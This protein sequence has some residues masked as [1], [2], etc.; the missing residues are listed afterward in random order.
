MAAGITFRIGG[1]LDPSYRA[2]LAQS[3]TEAKAA[4]MQIEAQQA[5]I[6]RSL[7]MP[8]NQIYAGQG[9]KFIQASQDLER[10][11]TAILINENAIRDSI[12]KK[13]QAYKITQAAAF[14]A[15]GQT[16]FAQSMQQSVQRIAAIRAEEAAMAAATVAAR[17]QQIAA[18]E[19]IVAGAASGAGGGS[20]GRA[21]MT[22]VIRESLVIMR[23]IAMGRGGPR[24][25]G[26]ATLLAQYLG[27]LNKAVKSTAATQV[28][29][30]A[31]AQKLNVQMAAQALMAKGTAAETELLAASQAQAA[32]TA[33]ALKDE[34]L[35]LAT[36]TVTLNPI[37]FLVVAAIVAVAATAGYLIYHYHKLAVQAKNL[38]DALN[39]LKRKY[40][41]LAAEQEKAAR[42]TKEN[43]DWIKELTNRHISESEQIERKIKLLKE[44]Q[45][46]R[47]RMMEASGVSD[48]ELQALDRANLEQ[49]KAMLEVQQARLKT[50]NE[51][52]MAAEQAASAAAIAGTTGTDEKGRVINLDQAEAN[53]KRRGEILDA[54]QEAMDTG[55][56]YS[57]EVDHY[58]Q[59][60]NVA[61]PVYKQRQG[62]ESDVVTFK[63]DGKEFSMSVADARKN[64]DFMSAQ[65]KKLAADQSALDDVLK[66][67]KSTAKEKMDAQN[68]VNE[69]L[70]NVNAEIGIANTSPRS[71]RGGSGRFATERERVG[72]GAPQVANIQ[73]QAL[74]VAKQQVNISAEMDKK[75]GQLLGEVVRLNLNIPW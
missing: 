50:E 39:P 15:Q 29:A 69:D 66:N 36:A 1:A 22:G 30:A 46:A 71:R 68:R 4:G 38:A 45:A 5:R 12:D 9:Y 42:A 28:M 67:T 7:L 64:F 19:A 55:T 58:Q 8:S 13:Y 24:V 27:L 20:H 16:F 57:S 2:S 14:A 21:G 54:A 44:E 73:K 35:A 10:K 70:E 41:E 32:I 34:E 60:G 25:A 11:K 52:A 43:A 3:V 59:A 31:A 61:V 37:F 33:E 40:T 6:R 75:M 63:V 65:A 62:N 72:I 53:A 48:A 56:F 23:E 74:D 51:Q 49:E 18:A 47:R 17:A 26:S